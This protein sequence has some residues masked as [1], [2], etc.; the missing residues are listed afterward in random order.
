MLN[1]YKVFTPSMMTDVYIYL[2]SAVFLKATIDNLFVFANI[3]RMLLWWWWWC[4]I[5]GMLLKSLFEEGIT[6]GSSECEKSQKHPLYT[7]HGP[8]FVEKSFPY[9]FL[10][11]MITSGLTV[12]DK[13]LEAG[14]N[15]WW[16]FLVLLLVL[17]GLKWWWCRS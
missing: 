12:L 5:S 2:C 3:G 11:F 16:W 1:L 8:C 15:G 10:L 9:L 6:T 14:V 7:K 17:L 4:R 13:M